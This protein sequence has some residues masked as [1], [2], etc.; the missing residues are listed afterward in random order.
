MSGLE[1]LEG[2]LKD[3]EDVLKTEFRDVLVDFW[4]PWCA[5]CRAL[6]PHLDR[7]SHEVTSRCRFVAVNTVDHP[8]AAEK[9]GVSSLPTLVLFRKEKE[10]HRFSDGVLVSH[11][12]DKLQ[13]LA[14]A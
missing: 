2:G 11:V 7:L 9:F 14:E 5:P 1:E 3:V 4:S 8:D 10:L 12:V 6:R 13:E